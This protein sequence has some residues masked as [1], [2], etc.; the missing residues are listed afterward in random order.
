VCSC[1]GRCSS[2]PTATFTTTGSI[3]LGTLPADGTAV[4]VSATGALTLHGVSKTVTV[5]LQV[6][7][8]GGIDDYGTMELHLLFNHA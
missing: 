4:S 2:G 7:R 6:T 5:P 8:S 3:D 1:R